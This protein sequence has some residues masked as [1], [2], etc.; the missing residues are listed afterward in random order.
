ML[1]RRHP[2][3]RRREPGAGVGGERGK[4]CFDTAPG[5]LEWLIWSKRED[6]KRQQTQGAEYRREAQWRTVPY[7]R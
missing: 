6:P 4:L 5:R 3:Y 1:P 2:A 7:E